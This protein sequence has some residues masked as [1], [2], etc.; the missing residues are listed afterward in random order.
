MPVVIGQALNSTL[1][2]EFAC[3]GSR[4]TFTCETRGSDG[5]AWASNTYVGPGGVRVGFVAGISSPGEVRTSVSNVDTVA[6]FIEERE[7]QGMTILK[8][9]LEITPLPEPQNASVTCIHTANV[10][11]STINFQVISK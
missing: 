1:E 10:E 3:L 11:R 7:E 2:S 9:M 4:V 6:T 8:S 5:I